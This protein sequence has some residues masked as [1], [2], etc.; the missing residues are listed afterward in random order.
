[1]SRLNQYTKN[2]QPV[3]FEGV[4]ILPH[5]ACRDL[6]I[7]GIVLIGSSF[8]E[9]F[10]RNKLEPRWGKTEELQKLEAEAFFYGERFR[11]LSEAEKYNCLVFKTPDEAWEK[12]IE[13]LA[14]EFGGD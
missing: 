2:T 10:K 3:I 5:L 4:N 6:Q 12:A 13:I 1:M 11:Y 9:V 14:G 7:P 8:E